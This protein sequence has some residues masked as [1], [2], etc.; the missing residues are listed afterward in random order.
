MDVLDRIS[1][2]DEAKQTILDLIRETSRKV[3]DLSARS[4]SLVSS[5]RAE[6]LKE[7]ASDLGRW[8]L[9]LGYTYNLEFL[10]DNLP[11]LLHDLGMKLHRIG[12]MRFYMDGG[13]SLQNVVD[14]VEQA[15]AEMGQLLQ[16]LSR[17]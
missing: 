5:G 17:F 13:K 6:E 14:M 15:S 9:R 3:S 8:L 7:T 16:F 4:Q 2:T 1:L 10:G 12:A 11:K